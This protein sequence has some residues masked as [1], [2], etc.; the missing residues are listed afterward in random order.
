MR[1]HSLTYPGIAA[2]AL[3]GCGPGAPPSL[4]GFGDGDGDHETIGDG[5]GEVDTIGDGDGDGDH[6]CVIEGE[7]GSQP[8]FFFEEWLDPSRGDDF[9]NYCN[10]GGADYAVSWTA[11]HTGFF[12]ALLYGDVGFSLTVLRGDCQGS[13]EGCA[14]QEFPSIIDFEAIAGERYT[15]VVDAELEGWFGLELHPLDLM[16]GDCPFGALFGAQETVFG[17]TVGASSDFGSLCGGG[18]TPDVEYLFFPP[19]TGLYRIDTFG[20]SFDTVLSVLSGECQWGTHLECNDDAMGTLQSSIQLLL[21]ANEVYT[22][23]VDGF[24][25][26]GSYQLN[27]SLIDDTPELCQDLESLPPELPALVS[28]PVDATTGDAWQGCGMGSFERRFLWLPPVD[29][30]YRVIQFAEGMFSSVSVLD[31]CAGNGGTCAG[32]FDS[33]ELMVET[34]AGEPHIIVSEW[35]PIAPGNMS[36]LIDLVEGSTGC[37][38]SLGSEVPLMF[39]GSTVGAGDEYEGS[40]AVMAAP[41]RELHWTAPSAGTYRFSLEGSSYDTLMYIRDGGCDGVELGCNDDTMTQFGLE[42]WSSLELDLSAGQTI[43]IF[44][45]GFSSGG[46]FV[47]SISQI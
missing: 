25:E 24:G 17:S 4:E 40:C 8:Q 41:E 26:V 6:P 39:A 38:E 28:W 31:D 33:V 1:F 47:L 15:F 2:L 19:V 35:E 29:G 44:V 42:L 16:P 18:D 45:D 12:R 10:D 37:G 13:F 32:G 34:L 3:A 22:I 5:D 14:A 9:P 30:T 23:V 21:F 43:S 20:S 46:E 11:P 7:V 27:V 36:L